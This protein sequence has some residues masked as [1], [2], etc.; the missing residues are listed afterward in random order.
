MA[1]SYSRGYRRVRLLTPFS[2]I[3][4]TVRAVSRREVKVVDEED[5]TLVTVDS[6]LPEEHR[7]CL[8]NA[9]RA[10]CYATSVELQNR[11]TSELTA[12]PIFQGK[13]IPKDFH[14]LHIKRSDGSKVN[15]SQF[16]VRASKDLQVFGRE[17]VALS[18]AIGDILQNIIEKRIARDPDLFGEDVEAM[19]DIMPLHDFT[20]VRPFTGL[21]ININSVTAAHKD[22]GD[23]GG[24]LVISL[25]SYEGGEMC[26]FQPRLAVETRNGDIV[27]FKSQDY[28]HFNL[29]YQVLST[30][31]LSQGSYMTSHVLT[32][33]LIKRG[34]TLDPT[35]PLAT[36]LHFL[37]LFGG[38]ETPY[39]SLH[40]VVSCGVMQWF[41]P[42]VGASDGGK[43]GGDTKMGI[44]MTKKKFAELE[45]S[46]LHLQ[47]N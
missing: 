14:P 46:L 38:E 30:S 33:A 6:T 10:F 2:N 11:D 8:R 27:S 28:I 41:D 24:C 17:F 43:E 25:G 39:E 26:L 3:K 12:P 15:H 9:I 32:L 35:T 45:L 40:A 29:H 16:Y 7:N 47:Q 23:L 21:V 20:P 37:N 18:E 31:L 44:P 13:P 1:F 34:A 42:F 4:L 5:K 36:Q 22:R 19:V